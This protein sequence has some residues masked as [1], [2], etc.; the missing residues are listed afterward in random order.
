MW[1]I[2]REENLLVSFVLLIVVFVVRF[3]FFQKH[4]YTRYSVPSSL[5]SIK[6]MILR[7]WTWRSILISLVI[8]PL[9]IQ[10]S[11]TQST[12]YSIIDSSQSMYSE[13]SSP[14]RMELTER[15]LQSVI[16]PKWSNH[17][18]TQTPKRH[19]NRCT[20]HTLVSNSGSSLGD[21]LGVGYEIDDNQTENKWIYLVVTD[22]GVNEGIS[23][24]QILAS[25]DKDRLIRVDILPGKRDIMISWKSIGV[26]WSWW[27]KPSIPH[28]IS[29]KN[30]T[31][32]NQIREEIQTI[33]QTLIINDQNSL[34]INKLLWLRISI[35]GIRLLSQHLISIGRQT[36]IKKSQ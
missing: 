9:D 17:C 12:I 7:R 4:T 36:R 20:I 21:L 30:P 5:I 34:S 25:S 23:V 3:L 13:D 19:H 8:I 15:I 26:Q 27:Y 14:T 35:A 22:W 10:R 31:E 1:S 29:M 33:L 2:G 28:Y 32:L 16:S 18:I 24:D 6:K 11:T